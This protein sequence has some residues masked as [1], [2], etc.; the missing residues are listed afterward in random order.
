[1]A[2]INE[3]NSTN[4]L[5]G[6]NQLNDTNQ[7]R[8]VSEPTEPGKT[9]LR[10]LCSYAVVVNTRPSSGN[11]NITIEGVYT[12]FRDAV[13]NLKSARLAMEDG[14]IAPTDRDTREAYP[15]RNKIGAIWSEGTLLG[16]G[17][18]WFDPRGGASVNRVWIA[19]TRVWFRRGDEAIPNFASDDERDFLDD[20][21]D[22][23]FVAFGQ[24]L[25]GNARFDEDS[26]DVIF[27]GEE[28]EDG[29]EDGRVHHGR[30]EDDPAEMDFAENEL[31]ME[32]LEQ[33]ALGKNVL[34]ED[35]LEEDELEGDELEEDEPE[36][37]PFHKHHHELS[38]DDHQWIS[39]RGLEEENDHEY[40]DWNEADGEND[41]QEED[42]D[43]E[44][45]LRKLHQR[46][47]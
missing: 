41:V 44:Y 3:L 26:Q 2:D 31:A 45:E 19:R 30:V 28:E 21:S 11:D 1:M 47:L 20:T 9:G 46:G 33:N 22:I 43:D 17:Y 37:Y 13:T 4:Q 8:E 10:D 7:P 32:E 38:E 34:E 16:W 25:P 29:E 14:W 23:G 12:D 39:D 6:T 24:E 35:E 36:V 40:P 18:A 5:N 15:Y 42:W 27:P